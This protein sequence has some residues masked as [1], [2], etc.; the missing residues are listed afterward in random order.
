MTTFG[1]DPVGDA[2]QRILVS[3]DAGNG[4]PERPERIH[5]D[6]K[7]E[8]GRRNRRGEIA[9]GQQE[10]ERAAE[11][12]AGEAACMAN[13]DNSG[14]L[15]LGIAD[16]GEVI[17]TNLDVEW[18]RARV[19]GLTERML[20]IQVTEVEV[21]ARRVL[22]IR[23]PQAVD[24]IRYRGRIMWRVNDS[25]VEVDL[26]TWHERRMI[27]THYDWS[28]QESDVPVTAVRRLP[29]SWSERSSATPR[30]RLRQTLRTNMTR[31]CSV[32]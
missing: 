20:T 24:A 19:Y 15:I 4:L 7:E 21:A 1:Y 5:V 31:P 3:I 22:I 10:N 25:C 30:S 28:A 32:G 26:A 23:P 9:P 8:A 6:L 16:D 11:Q 14:A 2:V 17:G 29:W 18:L 27:R 12:V 13:T